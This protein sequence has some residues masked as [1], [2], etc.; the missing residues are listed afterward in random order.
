MF[1]FVR[2]FVVNAREKRQHYE[3]LC[4][5]GKEQSIHDR[6]HSLNKRPLD[7][8]QRLELILQI[9]TDVVGLPEPK[10]DRQNSLEE[11][12]RSD[13][14]T[15]GV[16]PDITICERQ[17]AEKEVSSIRRIRGERRKGTYINFYNK[18]FT[19]VVHATRVDLGDIFAEGEGLVYHK[20]V[21]LDRRSFSSEVIKL[22]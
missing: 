2:D 7:H 6:Q 19:T 3:N 21:V 22:L 16:S 13:K 14:G 8:R 18:S 10:S 11:V 12:Q 17:Q 9:L 20:L 1:R 4:K 5:R 15:H